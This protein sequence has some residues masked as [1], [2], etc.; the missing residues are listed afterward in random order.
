MT[1]LLDKGIGMEQW[2]NDNNSYVW[3]G[4]ESGEIN[5]I[6]MSHRKRGSGSLTSFQTQKV[7][8]S[9]GLRHRSNML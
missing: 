5:A 2:A 3:L 8:G 7:V 6:M 9:S 1:A 4:G